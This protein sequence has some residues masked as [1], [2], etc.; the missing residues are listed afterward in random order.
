MSSTNAF[1]TIKLEDPAGSLSWVNQASLL[2]RVVDTLLGG[3]SVAAV[4]GGCSTCASSWVVWS[5]PQV[6]IQRPARTTALPHSL[7]DLKMLRFQAMFWMMPWGIFSVAN[8]RVM[9]SLGRNSD[10]V[11]TCF[12]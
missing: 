10:R 8:C 4:A 12:G 3:S 6:W 7:Q 2:L 5:W 9:F 11:P 1:L